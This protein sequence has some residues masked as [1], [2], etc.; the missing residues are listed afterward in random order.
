MKDGYIQPIDPAHTQELADALK[1]F[2]SKNEP[3]HPGL[4]K[5]FETARA[6][7]KFAMAEC[8]D[9]GTAVAGAANAL[10]EYIMEN[11]NKVQFTKPYPAE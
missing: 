9:Y 1:Q 6:K 11:K 8:P 10:L 4:L 5:Q 3:K 7:S 2:A